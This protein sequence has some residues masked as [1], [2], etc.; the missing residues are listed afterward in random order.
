MQNRT[1]RQKVDVKISTNR[2]PAPF[3]AS[4]FRFWAKA[5]DPDPLHQS[6]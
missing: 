2:K 3:L 6:N 5:C 1:R 4:P